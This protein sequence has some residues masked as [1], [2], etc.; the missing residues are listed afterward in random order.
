MI[1]SSNFLLHP[2]DHYFEKVFKVR[3]VMLQLVGQIFNDAQRALLDV[4]SLSL[5]SESF[6]SPELAESLS[7]LI[8]VCN[9]TGGAKSVFVC[10]LSTKV[11]TPGDA[12][13]RRCSGI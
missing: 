2:H 4:S 8:Y 3:P 11:A 5:A 10:F 12:S 13:I 9:L 6:I 7:D 1:D